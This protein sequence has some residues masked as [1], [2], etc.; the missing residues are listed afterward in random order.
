MSERYSAKKLNTAKLLAAG[1]DTH[2]TFSEYL[3]TFNIWFPNRQE[4]ILP[5]MRGRKID[6]LRKPSD[7]VYADELQRAVTGRAL[8]EGFH[9]VQ[10][11]GSELTE[12]KDNTRLLRGVA[13]LHPRRGVLTFEDRKDYAMSS[14]LRYVDSRLFKT[15]AEYLESLT[16][17]SSRE[18]ERIMD[19]IIRYFKEDSK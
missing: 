19:F 1:T 15:E 5:I 13:F 6:Q 8:Y 2:I 11:L 16:T 7:L 3:A 4:L 9:T 17:Q 14:T 10:M 12:G 18:P